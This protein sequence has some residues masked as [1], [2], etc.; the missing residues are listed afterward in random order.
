ML[1]QLHNTNIQAKHGP[2]KYNKI[3]IASIAI[4]YRECCFFNP[5]R[6]ATSIKVRKGSMEHKMITSQINPEETEMGDENNKET[7]Y[8][9]WLE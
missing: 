5:Q 4:S 3:H 2:C 9:L 7:I 8:H 1:H 6:Y